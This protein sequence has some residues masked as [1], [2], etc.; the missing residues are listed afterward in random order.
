[1]RRLG[2]AAI[3]GGVLRIAD[4]FT[5]QALPQG[6]LAALYF[7]TDVLLLAGIAGLWRQRR[8]T[9]GLAGRIG[10]GVFVLGI[11]AIRA[12]AF[13]IGS[14]RLGAAV[15]LLGLALYAAEALFGGARWA[16][17]AWLAALAAGLAAAAGLVPDAMTALAGVAFGS[18]FVAAGL[19]TL[20]GAPQSAQT[21]TS[22]VT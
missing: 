21:A 7:A 18:G 10:L 9:L 17:G 8:A 15:A 13:G 3:S 22:T 11:L 5:A 4:A 6:M 19:E 2:W 16:P 12:S 1:M 20:Y 14:Y